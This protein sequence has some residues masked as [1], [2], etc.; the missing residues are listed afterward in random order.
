MKKIFCLLSCIAFCLS[1]CVASLEHVRKGTVPERDTVV[2]VGKISFD[3]P[4][5]QDKSGPSIGMAGKFYSLYNVDSRVQPVYANQ[6]DVYL[7][8]KSPEYKTYDY[9]IVRM[10]RKYGTIHM[11]GITAYPKV[12]GFHQVILSVFPRLPIE[13]TGKEP[14]IYIGDIVFSI[15]DRTISMKVLD[16]HEQV[17]NQFR[18][19]VVGADGRVI[20]PAKKLV[21]VNPD[22]TARLTDVR[23]RVIYQQR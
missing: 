17:T 20:V 4:L 9:F 5:T 3:P 6:A 18:G 15:V 10:P 11:T 13:L 7:G 19:Y 2:I 1:G 14:F 12:H 21:P 23:T 16:R 22:L 8:H